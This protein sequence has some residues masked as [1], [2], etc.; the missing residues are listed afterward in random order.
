MAKEIEPTPRLDLDDTKKFLEKL[1][2]P[3][4][5]EEKEFMMDILKNNV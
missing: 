5:K 2:K 4:S 1:E 3:V